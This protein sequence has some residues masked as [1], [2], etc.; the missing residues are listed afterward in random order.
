MEINIIFYLFSW[1]FI[2][3]LKYYEKIA[4]RCAFIYI[5]AGYHIENKNNCLNQTTIISIE[6]TINITSW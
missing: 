5:N 4:D 2:Y 3:I 6:C 1:D